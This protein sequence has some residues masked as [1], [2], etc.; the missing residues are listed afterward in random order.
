MLK[1]S[2]PTLQATLHKLFNLV[3]ESGYFPVIWNHGLITPIF[4]N[5][6]RLDPNNYRGIC[7]NSSLG[8]VFC[9][10]INA[11]KLYFLTKHNVLSKNQIGFLPKYRTSDHIYSLHTLIKNY[12]KIKNIY[13]K[14][15]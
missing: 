2:S 11:R 8:K 5:G 14:N 12:T 6:D 4:K 10:I 15:F 3:L 7:V 1:H 13:F 9:S